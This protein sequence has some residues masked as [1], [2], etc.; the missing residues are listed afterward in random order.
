MADRHPA[1]PAALLALA[2][3]TAAAGLLIWLAVA[4]APPRVD[5]L[6]GLGGRLP[7]ITVL[8]VSLCQRIQDW[9]LIISVACG[10]G[11]FAGLRFARGE[12][13][14]PVLVAGAVATVALLLAGALVWFGIT[15]PI[16]ELRR[17][18]RGP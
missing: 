6:T 18:V 7:G 2:T 10:G 11:L 13:A 17:A 15:L 1:A 9:L 12:H 3:A 16:E 5:L 8:A 4:W 14:A